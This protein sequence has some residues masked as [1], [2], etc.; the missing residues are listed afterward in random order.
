MKSKTMTPTDN[1]KSNKTDKTSGQNNH[2]GSTFNEKE[3]TMGREIFKKLQDGG[4]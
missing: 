2:M 3:Q 4:R 1:Y